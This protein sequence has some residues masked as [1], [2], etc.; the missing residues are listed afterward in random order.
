MFN[1]NTLNHYHFMATLA[2]VLSVLICAG[3]L[4]AAGKPPTATADLTGLVLVENGVSR[5]PIV[6]FKDAPPFTRRAADELAQAKWEQVWK[7]ITLIKKDY[8][9]AISASYVSPGNRYL[10]Q[11]S[12]DQKIEVLMEDKPGFK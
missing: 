3:D 1:K 11:Y 5:V 6:V 10:Q 7:E 12:P 4:W 8:P 9:F 2:L